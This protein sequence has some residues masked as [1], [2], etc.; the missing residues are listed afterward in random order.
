MLVPRTERGDEM[1]F[2]MA[3]RAAIHAID[4]DAEEILGA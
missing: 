4:L 2:A 1:F 3:Q